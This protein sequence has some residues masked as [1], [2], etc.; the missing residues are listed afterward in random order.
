MLKTILNNIL[1]FIM[2]EIS[3]ILW[4][5]IS[6]LMCG[7]HRLSHFF[8]KLNF[9][10]RFNGSW[11]FLAI[12][13][14]IFIFIY[15]AGVC[16]LMF[17]EGSIFLFIGTSILKKSRAKAEAAKSLALVQIQT[18]SVYFIYTRTSRKISC[19]LNNDSIPRQAESC[20]EL[21]KQKNGNL[22][23]VYS[24]KGIGGEISFSLRPM[25]GLLCFIIYNLRKY[26][27]YQIFVVV[28]SASRIARTKN[29][30]LAT[31]E[32][33]QIL[34]FEFLLC[35]LPNLMRDK[36]PKAELFRELIGMQ[37]EQEKKLIV[38]QLGYIKNRVRGR[39]EIKYLDSLNISMLTL[40]GK[41]KVEGRNSALQKIPGLYQLFI[42]FGHLTIDEL[43]IKAKEMGLKMPSSQK[44]LSRS[45]IA[46]NLTLFRKNLAFIN[47]RSGGSKNRSFSS[48]ISTR[49]YSTKPIISDE[50]FVLPD[51]TVKAP[52]PLD[53]AQKFIKTQF[54]NQL[55]FC[56]M[57]SN[58]YYY[59]FKSD[60]W[61]LITELDLQK[62]LI[63]FFIGHYKA[64]NKKR[65]K[66]KQ[67]ILQHSQ[68]TLKNVLL[69]LKQMYH[70]NEWPKNSDLIAFNNGIFCLKSKSLLSFKPKH[71]IKSKLSYNFIENSVTKDISLIDNW[72]LRILG[73][74]DKVLLVKNFI[75]CSFLN[76]ISLQKY[77][78]LIGPGRTGKSTLIEFI[79]ACVGIEN[80][81]N[82]ELVYLEKSR[83]ELSNL[84]DKKLIIISD[85]ERYSGSVSKLKQITGGDNLRSEKKYDP[86]ITKFKASGLVIIAANEPIQATDYS[87][88]LSRRR[89]V[90]L[91]DKKIEEQALTMISSQNNILTG[92]LADQ[93]P[94]FI[95]QILS[96]FS[97]E[98]VLEFFDK[99]NLV[100]PSLVKEREFLD[101]YNP[102][103]A[104][105]DN[106]LE[107]NKGSKLHLG[108]TK[109]SITNEPTE[110][111]RYL[112]PNYV[113]FCRS[114]GFKPMNSQRLIY[115]LLDHYNSRLKLSIERK[116]DNRGVYLM[117]LSFKSL[118]RLGE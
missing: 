97:K 63:Y 66:A 73:S 79:T 95:S 75:F 12:S 37:V 99:L 114:N 50:T 14:F 26:F 9:I 64:I 33:S 44:A 38:S 16:N 104:Y 1:A 41:I 100:V 107:Y 25:G 20:Y 81:V 28:E 58:W 51:L 4:N 70:L 90:L 7:V 87:T 8:N 19:T 11:L 57:D 60:I 105:A 48:L 30:L 98:I 42:E 5:R 22:L 96:T 54:N 15:F 76:L 2:K 43:T 69:Y 65:V 112:Y 29:N 102:I 109:Y 115:L 49:S 31:Y 47:S 36:G 10:V 62:K 45:S 27:N 103:I 55:C 24:D 40:D 32:L 35:L 86:L 78:E 88:G 93:L 77:L 108:A 6:I 113:Q 56:K 3:F 101:D 116:K 80:T 92:I 117:N 61:V 85:S 82:T 18:Y 13:L 71:F 110:A 67:S 111:Y 17:G 21:I 39:N 59:D 106:C 74:A 23:G 84:E 34:G 94:I 89:I 118:E 46:R 53:L 68:S 91:L 52:T 72:L 83:F